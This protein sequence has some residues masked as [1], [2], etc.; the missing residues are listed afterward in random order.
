[1]N[2]GLSGWY[3]L[4]MILAVLGF[5]A[6]VAGVLGAAIMRLMLRDDVYFPEEQ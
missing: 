6:V 4:L 1:M 5:V 3:G 2:E